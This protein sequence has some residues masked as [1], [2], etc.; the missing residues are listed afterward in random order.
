MTD[1]DT[2]DFLDK[3]KEAEKKTVAARSETLKVL[4]K[5][6]DV[7]ANIQDKAK[8]DK[9]DK[10]NRGIRTLVDDLEELFDEPDGHDLFE[11]HIEEVKTLAVYAKA[12]MS[13]W[14]ISEA[15]ES[16]KK[17][18][19][20]RLGGIVDSLVD[21]TRMF[22]KTGSGCRPLYDTF[23]TLL[24]VDLCEN[25]ATIMNGMWLALGWQSLI[26]FL[27]VGPGFL[28]IV[29]LASPEKEYEDA[30]PKRQLKERPEKPKPPPKPEPE[31]EPEEEPEPETVPVPEP[32]PEPEPEPPPKEESKEKSEPEPPPVPKV[33]YVQVPAKRVIPSANLSTITLISTEIW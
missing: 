20:A 7:T 5:T 18:F 24:V 25:T 32:E 14:R 11:D 12:R 4:K 22:L 6:K 30:K 31:P 29:Q 10:Q 21:E 3:L 13:A 8:A 26:L 15:I 19:V 1:A 23:H 28:L 16:G 2:D 33:V 27:A 9:V 17:E